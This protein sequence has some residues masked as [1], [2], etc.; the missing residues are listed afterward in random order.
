M[1]IRTMLTY[2]VCIQAIAVVFPAV[3][4]SSQGS[5]AGVQ[6]ITDDSASGVEEI[7]VTAQRRS[8]SIQN[9]PIAISAVTAATAAKQGVVGTESL[10][11]VI[12]A[13]QFTRQTGNG[14]APFLRAVG[15]SQATAGTNSSVATYIDDVYLSSPIATTL[16][17]NNIESVE[18][19]KGP[20]GTLFGRNA[21]GGVIHV[22]TR[23]PSHV[24]SVEGLVGYGSYDTLYGS[25][26]ATTGV[27]DNLAVNIAL[28]G[29]NQHD[30]YGRNLFNGVDIYKQKN[31]GARV[32]ILWEPTETTKVNISGDYA[33]NS[34]DLG[35][36]VVIAPGTIALGG[37]GFVCKY[38]SWDTP[39]G[40][41]RDN[42]ASK[43]YGGSVKIAQELGAIKFLSISAYHQTRLNI[44]IQLDGSTNGQNILASRS[45]SFN[46]SFSQEFQLLSKGNSKVQWILGAFYFNEYAGYD[47]IDLIGTSLAVFGGV[48]H[49]DS[50]QLLHSYS[51][52][53][54]GSY[55][56]LPRTKL[57]LGLRYT[58]DKFREVAEQRN[59]AQT[60]LPPGE[61][62]SGWVNFSKLTYRAILDYKPVDDVLFYGS[63]SRGFKSGGFST[64][65]PFLGRVL[66]PA[67]AP[68]VLDA[69]EVGFKSELADNRIRLNGS[70]YYY[71]YTNLQVATV[72]NGAA[73]TFNAA[74]AHIKGAELDL[75]YAPSRRLDFNAGVSY[76]DSK[77]TN[78]P[79]G[80]LNVP[81]P[82]TCTPFP[83]T[84][85]PLAG[86]NSACFVDLSGNRTPRAPKF[87]LSMR[88]TYNVPTDFGDF[89]ANA[90]FYHNSGFFWEPDNRFAQPRYDI[91]NASLTW[92]SI[93]DKYSLKAY[94]KNILDE[95]YYSYF[96]ESSGRDAG[97]PEMPRNYGVEFGFKF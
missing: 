92:K 49:T 96:A 48:R 30:G 90:T 76:L 8:E 72:Q 85:G 45:P 53:G 51:L 81:N 97:S 4:Q 46:K 59:A 88:A 89:S 95:Y 37:G 27:T 65:A 54:E 69:F 14:G 87:T 21:T 6:T 31:A 24:T 42:G 3:A 93:D 15:T 9:V 43:V 17:F 61:L 55:E 80:P 58:T 84:T 34:G 63:Y 94:A 60:V 11:I 77:F 91:L 20:Q 16:R 32:G 29:Q 47:P 79:A 10:G 35:M 38:C 62:S 36:N 39:Y 52:F 28:T 70:A 78:F 18:V 1:N 44:D 73:V 74:S 41:P 12:P 67:V 71:D 25:L 2:G 40:K 50:R 86:G 75:T 26:Y 13:L 5:S 57:T 33:Y 64:A 82:R 7:V 23:Q 22:H 19:L 68:E 66:A 56:I 83:M